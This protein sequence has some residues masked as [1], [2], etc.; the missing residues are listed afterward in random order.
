MADPVASD[1][2]RAE[3]ADA[4]GPA[5]FDVFL[6]HN[7]RDKP[8]VERVAE[9]LKRVG[10]EPWLDAWCLVPG[11]DWQTGLAAGL[12]HSGACAVFV[13]P[14]DVG[15]WANQEVGL[16]LDR[17]AKDPDFRLFLVLLPGLPEPFESE[18]LSP[19]LRLR[20]WVD[21]RGGLDDQ[22]AFRSLLSAVQGLPLG[23]EVPIEARDDIC[24]YRG[25]EAF[26][27]EH[28]EF[29]FGRDGDVQ[30][31]VERFK[32]TRFLAVLGASGSGKS[33]LVR[34]GLLPALRRGALAGSAEWELVLLRPGA[35][36]LET[37]SGRLVGLGAG[38]GMQATLDSLAS[39]ARTLHLATSLLL[40]DRSPH[41]HVMYV[42]D[43]F[44]EV[45]TLCRDEAE[46]RAF[47]ANLLYAAS[48][49]DGRSK[50][51]LTLRADFYH[52]CAAY[53]E[54]AQQLA[55]EQYLVSPLDRDGLRQAI[56]EPARRVGLSFEPG[57]ARTIVDDVEKQPGTL[58]LLEHALLELWKRRRA[59]VLTLAAYHESGGVEEA[60]AR[61][62]DEIFATFTSSQQALARRTFL[63]LT[64][65]GEG[66]EDTRR[67]AQLE[68]LSM[69]DARED[70][71]PVLRQLVDARL[72][73]TSRDEVGGTEVVEVAH[74]A[75][76]R[77]WPR[78]R[79][80]I[81]EDR[82]GLRVHRRLTEA[83][84][85]W[86]SLG[87]DPSALYR[88]A[89]LAA[90]RE[91]AERNEDALNRQEQ[92]FLDASTTLEHDELETARSRARRFRILAVVLAGL[93][94]LAAAAGGYA[95]AQKR[96]ADHQQEIATSRALAA[97]AVLNMD[98]RLDVAALLAV[99]AWRT[100]P[101]IEARNALTTAVQRVDRVEG[102]LRSR[103]GI[104]VG[105]LMFADDGRTLL[106][107]GLNSNRIRRWDIRKR[108]ELPESLPAGG[109]ERLAYS[110]AGDVLAG[111]NGN[112]GV[113]LWALGS[114]G[115]RS[116]PDAHAATLAFS[117]D[118]RVLAI[119]GYDGEV[120]TRLVSRPGRAHFFR[121]G[122]F[123]QLNA[124]SVAFARNGKTLVAIRKTLVAIRAEGEL[125]NRKAVVTEWNVASGTRARPDIHLPVAP[126]AVS[127]SPAGER[128]AFTD[129]AELGLFGVRDGHLEW[130]VKEPAAVRD[131]DALRFSPDGRTLA[132]LHSDGTIAL[133][134]TVN[135][136]LIAI[137]AGNRDA[138]AIAFSPD[139]NT[140]A[141]SGSEI[142][143]LWHITPSDLGRRLEA[144][145]LVPATSTSETLGPTWLRLAF[146]PGS[147][148]LVQADARQAK[149]WRHVGQRTP[150]KTYPVT[151]ESEGDGVAFSR[152]GLIAVTGGSG[153]SLVDTRSKHTTRSLPSGDAVGFSD[154][155][156]TLAIANDDGAIQLWDVAANPPRHGRKTRASGEVIWSVAFS[157]DGRQL[158]AAGYGQPV[159]VWDIRGLNLKLRHKLSNVGGA[160]SVA[161]SGDGKK[162]A[163]DASGN[164]IRLWDARTGKPVG[165]PIATPGRVQSVAF[166]RDGSIVAAATQD[167]VVQLWDARSHRSL[168][169][170]IRGYAVAFSTDGKYLA[171]GM[172]NAPTV[173]PTA[174]W[175]DPATFASRLCAVASRNLTRGEWDEFSSGSWRKT[176]T[177]WPQ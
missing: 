98:R 18:R 91:W 5:R 101:T 132:I 66:T 123:G 165:E 100:S 56:E 118:G 111:S 172:P 176:C 128:A 33:S 77:G 129:G 130:D 137:L 21:F 174:L 171:T 70:L 9:Q 167:G 39:D 48:F 94:V 125:T 139:G 114:K 168:G 169:D 124:V 147:D 135:G 11:T 78:L 160:M 164:T 47:F 27:E 138:R 10:I 126:I 127:F 53:P 131:N 92:A 157:P 133:R 158:A 16:A 74:E 162:I 52:R 166:S 7:S 60:V 93:L 89:R 108:K 141:A 150:P 84:L 49:P 64:Q 102:F 155:G 116:V 45:F 177:H 112:G 54:L 50:V 146:S 71:D 62:A 119:G 144:G 107:L 76:I 15:A 134:K 170:P 122:D 35:H 83:A 36:P 14:A 82:A 28:A 136:H 58:P 110:P 59:G 152:R 140:L 3:Q 113:T 72:L 153:V 143:T 175:Q 106:V 40:A 17:A 23:P 51:L 145:P 57:L 85:D 159:S 142:V 80:W 19:F 154:G 41:A 163:A 8:F 4:H 96:S 30:R 105:S 109:T 156:A 43:Q 149:V 69:A 61:R 161:F 6:S 90:A 121:R 29:F 46:R 25:L 87:R 151:Y 13:G 26:D 31:L 81:D 148:T 22:R 63:R 67:R 24:P 37:L 103:N 38:R 97:Q 20:T 68:E 99:Q 104:D 120:T 2:H 115:E 79:G 73:I 32:S 86:E 44:E 55:A 34:A 75:L 95:F 42:V 117:P 88:G 12:E 1:E 173:W 65:P